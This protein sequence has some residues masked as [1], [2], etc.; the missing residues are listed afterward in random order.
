LEKE[1]I[2]ISISVGVAVHN[3][4]QKEVFPVPGIA[5]ETA[6]LMKASGRS[7]L[8]RPELSFIGSHLHAHYAVVEDANC[9]GYIDSSQVF[10]S[11]DYLG[12]ALR[13]WS[14]D[15]ESDCRPPC[16][17]FVDDESIISGFAVTGLSRPDVSTAYGQKR[18]SNAG[19]TGYA[20][21][22]TGATGS[23]T[24]YAVSKDGLKACRFAAKAILTP[25]DSGTQ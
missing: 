17:V 13:G 6:A 1:A 23:L 24:A 7:L 3:R 4:I 11:G 15:F 25:E 16:I 18:M 12:V 5:L 10:P 2:A 19:W 14:W 22:R 9:K 20:R 21:M 8:A